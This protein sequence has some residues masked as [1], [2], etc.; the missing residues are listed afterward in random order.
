MRII[1]SIEDGEIIKAIL[2]HLGIWLIKSN[3]PPKAHGPP[4][5][6]HVMDDHSQIPINDDHLYR[7]PEYP[8]DISWLSV[9]QC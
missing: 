4:S 1:S 6:E 3:P 2:K 8:W 9:L 7:D 5:V